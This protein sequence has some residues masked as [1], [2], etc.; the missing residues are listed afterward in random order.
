MR[1]HDRNADLNALDHFM[2]HIRQVALVHEHQS[3][4]TINPSVTRLLSHILTDMLYKSEMMR[5][6]D[7]VIADNPFQRRIHLAL[8]WLHIVGDFGLRY[9]H[10]SGLEK[11]CKE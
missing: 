6:G 7:D 2:Y 1:S 8:F 11:V 5:G 9:Y 3:S 4:S 10:D